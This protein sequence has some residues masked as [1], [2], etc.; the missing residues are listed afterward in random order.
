MRNEATEHDK[1]A[2]EMRAVAVRSLG[3]SARQAVKLRLGGS[4]TQQEGDAAWRRTAADMAAGSCATLVHDAVSTPGDV[5][6]QVGACA[7]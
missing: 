7:I 5:I 6:K 2:K 4:H 1:E 3:F